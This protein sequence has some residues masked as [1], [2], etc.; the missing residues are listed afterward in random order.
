MSRIDQE[1]PLLRFLLCF[2]CFVL[3]ALLCIVSSDLYC[4]KD[5]YASCSLKYFGLNYRRRI[6][7]LLL[8]FVCFV[9][10]A[11][12]CIVSSDLY[13]SKD[14]YFSCS[15][16]YFGVNYRRWLLSKMCSNKSCCDSLVLGYITADICW[17]RSTDKFHRIWALS[18]LCLA[19]FRDICF[20]DELDELTWRLVRLA[21]LFSSARWMGKSWPS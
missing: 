15:L 9:L 13:C 7:L 18:R 20:S 17:L 4:L 14:P 6:L 16:K 12:L 8:C 2:V 19:F 1:G 5:P 3:L 11:L 10:F 21:W